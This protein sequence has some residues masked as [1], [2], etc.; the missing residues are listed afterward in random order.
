L[1][2][3]EGAQN[4]FWTKERVSE[5]LECFRKG[6]A[7][8]LGWLDWKKA[9]GLPLGGVKADPSVIGRVTTST[10]IQSG[11]RFSAK[12]A[13]AFLQRDPIRLAALPVM[14]KRRDE[15]RWEPQ[16]VRATHDERPLAPSGRRG[17]GI[18]RRITCANGFYE[19]PPNVP[20]R[21]TKQ[22]ISTAG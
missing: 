9:Q 5:V 12:Y 4:R 14:I 8:A 17:S 3:P 1:I 13:A 20:A 10:L 21:I 11:A 18:V 6:E 16:A 15:R 2:G 19:N 7:L 22:K